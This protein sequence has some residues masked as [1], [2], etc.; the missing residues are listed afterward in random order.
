[1]CGGTV[2]WDGVR[3]S[4][5]EMVEKSGIETSER[6]ASVVS[7]LQTQDQCSII[8]SLAV[9]GSDKMPLLLLSSHHCRRQN[10]DAKGRIAASAATAIFSSLRSID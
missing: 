3:A 9:N 8:V 7:R 1:M 10:V 5:Y 6:Q 2:R 4:E